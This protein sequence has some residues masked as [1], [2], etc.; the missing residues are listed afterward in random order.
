MGNF[1]V[2]K[3]FFD[4]DGVLADFDRGI[5][6]LCKMVPLPQNA[7]QRNEEKENEMWAKVKEVGHF[8]DKLEP[9][10]GAKEM[11]DAVYSKYGDKCEI[12]TGIPKPWRGIVTSAEDK[13]NWMR[14]LFSETV[15]INTVLR[16]E[17][18]NFC[19]GKDCILIDDFDKNTREWT[20]I[21][22]TAILFTS[23]DETMK[24]MKEMGIL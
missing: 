3:I 2:K 19:T 11:F 5:V 4:M 18:K 16:A 9:I 22:G 13:V 8:Y 12:L 23:A 20:Q 6:E 14:R 17:K 24:T 1:E 10:P 7:K 21:G 15:K